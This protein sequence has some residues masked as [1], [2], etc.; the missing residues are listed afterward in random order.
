MHIART[1]EVVEVRRSRKASRRCSLSSRLSIVQRRHHV[2]FGGRKLAENIQAPRM[3]NLTLSA[4]LWPQL[5][6]RKMRVLIQNRLIEEVF[7]SGKP[8]LPEK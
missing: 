1:D 3:Q 7:G 5:P 6:E 2:L 8:A 4:N